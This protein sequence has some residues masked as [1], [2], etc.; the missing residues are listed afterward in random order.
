MTLFSLEQLKKTGYI[1]FDYLSSGQCYIL[2]VRLTLLFARPLIRIFR[3]NRCDM[4][5]KIF[6]S[7]LYELTGK[8]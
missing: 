4:S 2:N 7:F 5:T 1:F 6:T 8:V 3:Q